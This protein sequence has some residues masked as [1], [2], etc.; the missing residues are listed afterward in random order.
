[1]IATPL[2]LGFGVDEEI[3]AGNAAIA[4]VAEFARSQPSEMR[5]VLHQAASRRRSAG[6]PPL[7][8]IGPPNGFVVQA[9]PE[10]KSYGVR[11]EVRRGALALRVD[12]LEDGALVDDCDDWNT[13]TEADRK[14]AIGVAASYV[15]Q[16]RDEIGRLGLDVALLEHLWF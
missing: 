3:A 15:L 12:V 13:V 4:A 1:V 11:I 8:E 14:S 5:K 6:N 10:R 2:G 9:S 7:V 16:H